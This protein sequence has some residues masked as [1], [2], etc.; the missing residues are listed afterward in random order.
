MR[1]CR[2][3]IIANDKVILT[4]TVTST[5]GSNRIKLSCGDVPTRHQLCKGEGRICWKLDKH[6][7]VGQLSEL[8]RSDFV[9]ET[10]ASSRNSPATSGDATASSKKSLCVLAAYL[11][12]ASYAYLR[13]PPV[14]QLNSRKT[15]VTPQARLFAVACRRLL[16]L[17]VV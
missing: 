15:N 8:Q 12:S 1:S 4:G 2:E 5:S 13:I 9:E 11:T 7:R 14:G 10:A 6:R 17:W 16:G 3:L